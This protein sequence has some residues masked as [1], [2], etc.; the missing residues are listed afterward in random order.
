MGPFLC[1]LGPYPVLC[2]RIGTITSLMLSNGGDF[3]PDVATVLKFEIQR[4]AR[5][6]VRAAVTPLLKQVR[7][8]KRAQAQQKA[9]LSSLNRTVQALAKGIDTG[10]APA[11][12]AEEDV[13]RA[14]ISPASVRR[15][16]KRLKLSQ[17]Q[18]ADLLGVST[19]SIV[20]WEAGK[21]SPRGKNRA[22]FLG[23][24]DMGAQE[25]KRRL[26]RK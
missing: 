13:R 9:I 10:E 24:R 12:P 1:G 11:Q 7:E 18:M 23:V 20:G 26:G 3:M 4:L 22:A 19:G 25:A 17:K 16:R 5:K 14:R 8:L 15:Q 2:A 21:S 6:E